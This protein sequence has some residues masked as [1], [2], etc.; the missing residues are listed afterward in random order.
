M[1]K[2]DASSSNTT[3]AASRSQTLTVKLLAGSSSSPVTCTYDMV[4]TNTGETYTPTSSVTANNLKEYT[5]KI[6]NGSTTILAET[7]INKLNLP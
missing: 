2:T 6:M 4:W 1:I 3:V 5:L 7:N